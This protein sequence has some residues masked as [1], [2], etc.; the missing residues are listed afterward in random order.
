M[1]T[2]ERFREDMDADERA[3]ALADAIAAIR[4]ELDGE[5][6]AAF[7]RTYGKGWPR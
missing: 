3:E 1:S 4:D 7:E 2:P 5:E 6:A